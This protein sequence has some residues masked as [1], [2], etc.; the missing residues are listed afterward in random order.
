[1][2][3][4]TAR[5]L[6]GESLL[7]FIALKK[8]GGGVPALPLPIQTSKWLSGDQWLT[9]YRV[10]SVQNTEYTVYRVQSTEYT[11]Y[12]VQSTQCTE[13]RVHS[14]QSTVLVF[15]IVDQY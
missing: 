6:E 11:V 15:T 5:R 10:H 9:V 4:A 13:Y 12:R 14:V 3:I 2:H 1:M 8:G 7:P